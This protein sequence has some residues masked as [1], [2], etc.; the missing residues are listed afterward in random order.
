MKHTKKN[1]KTTCVPF[2]VV[3]KQDADESDRKSGVGSG[4]GCLVLVALG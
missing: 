4:A 3:A 2:S 1:R